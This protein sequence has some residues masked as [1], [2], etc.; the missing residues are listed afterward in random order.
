MKVKVKVNVLLLRRLTR[1][2]GGEVEIGRG[3]SG[4][5]GMDV[6]D[7]GRATVSSRGRERVDVGRL[8]WRKSIREK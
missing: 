1:V 8:G 7:D 2:L 6:D 5:E 4:S 3:G